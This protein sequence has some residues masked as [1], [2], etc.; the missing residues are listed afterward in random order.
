MVVAA[1]IAPLHT[2]QEKHKKRKV[3]MTNGL[4]AKIY[5]QDKQNLP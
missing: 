2:M 5:I 4:R 1:S 3:L